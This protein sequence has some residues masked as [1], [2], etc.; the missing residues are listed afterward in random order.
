[1]LSCSWAAGVPTLSLIPHTDFP[2]FAAAAQA[3]HTTHYAS[4]ASQLASSFAEDFGRKI[5]RA[6]APAAA[7]NG[8]DIGEKVSRATVKPAAG[9]AEGIG[10]KVS[11]AEVTPAAGVAEDIGE[12]ISRATVKPAADTAKDVGTKVDGGLAVAPTS[13]TSGD[14]SKRMSGMAV[15]T[16]NHPNVFSNVNRAAAA[17]GSHSQTDT[18]GARAASD[19][20]LGQE[21]NRP[22]SADPEKLKTAVSDRSAECLSEPLGNTSA[23]SEAVAASLL[24]KAQSSMHKLWEAQQ[25]SGNTHDCI[26]PVSHAMQVGLAAK[27]KRGQGAQASQAEQLG[28][29]GDAALLVFEDR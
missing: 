14:T 25:H 29:P 18:K 1:M 16:S 28:S 17:A 6:A 19:S 9:A 24:P 4:K 12:K 2:S 22:S 13:G 8:E 5:G 10:E 20:N 7:A 11:R 26:S 3:F 21:V 23:Q 15:A 27:P